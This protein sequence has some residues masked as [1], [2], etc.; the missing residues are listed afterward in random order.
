MRAGFPAFM[1]SLNGIDR[2][3]VGPK[4]FAMPIVLNRLATVS[5]RFPYECEIPAAKQIPIY[6][7][8]GNQISG[9]SRPRLR[10][11]EQYIARARP[12]RENCSRKCQPE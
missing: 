4:S 1:K 10:Q 5:G 9:E 6:V 7:L 3:L 12:D 8:P 2:W 11:I